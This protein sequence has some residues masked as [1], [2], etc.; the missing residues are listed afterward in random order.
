MPHL[1]QRRPPDCDRRRDVEWIGAHQDDVG[2]LDRDIGAGAYGN[3]EIGLG[4]SRSVVYAVPDHRHL[5][6]GSLQLSDLGGLV[7]GEDLGH[8]LTDAKL[9]GDPFGG[10]LVVACEHRSE[11]HTSELQSQFHLVCRLLLEKKKLTSSYS[12]A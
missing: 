5:L 6:A 1:A 11:E 2:G 7:G 8:H 10:G 4:Q 3:T 12:L 9:T